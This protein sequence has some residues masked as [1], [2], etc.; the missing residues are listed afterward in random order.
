MK[1][2]KTFL[3]YF[4]LILIVVFIRA[5]IIT[6]V[7]V[8]GDSMKETI[9]HNDILL[10][11]KLNSHPKKLKRFD[12][13][14]FNYYNEALIKRV[15]GLPGESIE[16]KDNKLLVDGKQIKEPLSFGKISNFSLR[17]IGSGYEKVPEGMY[18]VLGDNRNNSTDSRTIGFVS[19]KDIQGKVN[20]I[21]F[22]FK[23][24]GYVK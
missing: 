3:E 23:R 20:F 18:F 4:I 24:F 12:I 5:F 11:N 1:I 14:V 13:I 2:T 16:Y 19:K 15:I 9:H 10:L 21:L 17:Y 6:P 22:P 8:N 7:Q